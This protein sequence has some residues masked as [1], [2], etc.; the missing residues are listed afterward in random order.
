MK[1]AIH[2][3]RPKPTLSAY[4]KRMRF[5]TGLFMATCFVFASLFFWAISHVDFTIH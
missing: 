2:I 1:T 3:L 4:Q 5:F